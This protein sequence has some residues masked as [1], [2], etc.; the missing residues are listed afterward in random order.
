MSVSRSFFRFAL[1]GTAGFL[2]DATTLKLVL[3]LGADFYSG[4]LLSFFVAV[5][6]TWY[7]NR[8]YT[9]KSR[10]PGLLREWFRFVSANGVGGILNYV[11]YAL[12][13]TVFVWFENSP[14]AAVAA[15]SIVGLVSN[16]LLSHHVVFAQKSANQRST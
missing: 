15:G 5:T 4:R 14:V 10:E 6:F 13:V 11:T 3:Y 16:F 9:F 1:V 12:L 2:V 8:I 7:L